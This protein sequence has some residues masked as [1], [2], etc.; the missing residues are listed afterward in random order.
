MPRDNSKEVAPD[1][2]GTGVFNP[3]DFYDFSPDEPMIMGVYRDGIDLRHVTIRNFEPGQVTELHV[4]PENAHCIYI[5]EGSGVFLLGDMETPAEAGQFL[6]VPRGVPHGLRNTGG[7][8][9]SY[10]GVNGGAEPEA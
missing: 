2:L 5:M 1:T 8:R 6:I 9:L 7:T 3:S 10:L 4:H